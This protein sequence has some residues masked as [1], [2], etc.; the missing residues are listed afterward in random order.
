MT[1]HWQIPDPHL[2][3]LAAINTDIL[4]E[5][6]IAYL[7]I[8]DFFVNMNRF[9]PLLSDFYNEIQEYDHLI[10]DIRKS[11]GG[12]GRVGAINFMYPLWNEDNDLL[13]APLFAFFKNNEMA[14]SLGNASILVK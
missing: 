12:Y 10:I 6:Y 2:T 3:Q 14:Y 4:V 8:S 9:T 5:D 1:Y 11:S 7:E 13:D